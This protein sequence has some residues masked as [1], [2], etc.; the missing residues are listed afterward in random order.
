MYLTQLKNYKPPAIAVDT[1]NLATT[2]PLQQP[3]AALAVEPAD[4]ALD[5]D[6]DALVEAEWPKLVSPIDDPANYPGL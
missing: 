6:A 1:S 4:A 5:A 2:F 3:P